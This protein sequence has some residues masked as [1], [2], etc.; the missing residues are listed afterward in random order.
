MNRSFLSYWYRENTNIEMMEPSPLSKPTLKS[1]TPPPHEVPFQP[2]N[3]FQFQTLSTDQDNHS[4]KQPLFPFSPT[5]AKTRKGNPDD[6]Y[7]RDREYAV[8]P[9]D[10]SLVL[11][12][13]ANRDQVRQGFVYLTLL[14]LK[15]GGQ[16]SLRRAPSFS[17]TVISQRNL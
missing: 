16:E 8:T 6:L 10:S 14:L 11:C 5:R 2:N 3:W 9:I 4:P 7:R 15:I 1:T 13:T 12:E 17:L